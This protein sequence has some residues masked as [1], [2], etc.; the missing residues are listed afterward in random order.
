[1]NSQSIFNSK[2]QE[3]SEVSQ[4]RNKYIIEKYWERSITKRLF[5]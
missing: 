2:A 5:N 4:R 1:M 3:K